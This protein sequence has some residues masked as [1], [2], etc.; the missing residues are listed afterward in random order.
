LNLSKA[1]VL[2]VGENAFSQDILS[3]VLQGFGVRTLL[4]AGSAKAARARCTEQVLDLIFCDGEMAVE[5]G[6]DF[7]RWLRRAK[8]DPNSYVPVVVMATHTPTSKVGKARDCG[9]NFVIAKPI[10]PAVLLDRILWLTREQ[11][12]FIECSVY[13]GP[14]RRF[15]DDGAP[16]EGERRQVR[17]AAA[18]LELQRSTG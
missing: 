5:D 17:L 6:Y 9:A 7:V 18:A 8:L 4:R 15:R 12:P 16:A 10:A 11:R 2:L 14:E 13:F 3:K 1:E